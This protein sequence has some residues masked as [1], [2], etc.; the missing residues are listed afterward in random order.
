MIIFVH[1]ALELPAQRIYHVSK[2]GH[3][4]NPGTIQQPFRT[5]GRTNQLML[6]PGDQLLFKGGEIFDGNI[7]LDETDAGTGANPVRIASYGEGRATIYAGLGTALLAM[8]TEG[9]SV[10]NLVVKGDGSDTNDGSG[11]A[12]VNSLP[13]DRRL[14]YVRIKNISASGFGRDIKKLKGEIVGMQNPSGQGI[15]VGGTAVDKSKS[16]FNDVLIENCETFENEFYGILI[17]GYWQ[18]DPSR[19]IRFIN[20]AYWSP[21]GN[22]RAG[23]CLSFDQWRKNSGHEMLKGRETG[24]FADPQLTGNGGFPSTGYTRESLCISGYLIKKGSPLI[25]AG[26]DI[27]RL[28][29]SDVVRSDYCGVAFKPSRKPDIGAFEFNAD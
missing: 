19:H 23:G 21:A 10:E 9:I 26:L 25:D 13:G 29:K 24:M 17:S 2:N 4:E 11:I 18:D 20:N 8:N 16:G 5:I 3:D 7:L 27:R 14:S 28:F 15:F 1:I 6:K 12:V 22:F